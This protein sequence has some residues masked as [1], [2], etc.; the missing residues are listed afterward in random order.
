MNCELERSTRGVY[1][2]SASSLAQFNSWVHSLICL[3]LG[4]FVITRTQ[5]SPWEM[6]FLCGWTLWWTPH[7]QILFTSPHQTKL[8]TRTLFS[9]LIRGAGKANKIWE[10]MLWIEPC[11]NTTN[12]LQRY[13]NKALGSHARPVGIVSLLSCSSRAHMFPFS[14][15]FGVL[16]GQIH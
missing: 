8:I 1:K 10:E 16:G 6:Y 5:S 13:L 14:A 12:L 3:A 15:T 2:A 11:S 7:P 4:C 9:L